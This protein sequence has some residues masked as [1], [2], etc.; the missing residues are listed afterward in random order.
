M[1]DGPGKA[2]VVRVCG[3]CHTLARVV[4]RRQTPGQWQAT[5]KEMQGNGMFAPPAEL[6]SILNYLSKHYGHN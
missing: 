3:G 1:P 5:L 6:H 4:R 2:D